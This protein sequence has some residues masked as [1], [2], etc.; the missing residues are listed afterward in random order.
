[1]RQ[2]LY[3]RKPSERTTARYETRAAPFV[4]STEG[5]AFTAAMTNKRCRSGTIDQQTRRLYSIACGSA[6][7]NLA[8]ESRD[9]CRPCHGNCVRNILE[10]VGDLQANASESTRTHRSQRKY[11]SRQRRSRTNRDMTL[12]ARFAMKVWIHAR[13]APVNSR[14]CCRNRISQE[15][16]G[17]KEFWPGANQTSGWT[18]HPLRPYVL[19]ALRRDPVPSHF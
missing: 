11:N 4:K 10:F 18:N 15:N 1:M 2:C 3:T 12:D 8:F 14:T 6:R 17:G 19:D 16:G 13:S 7:R 9:S 5:T